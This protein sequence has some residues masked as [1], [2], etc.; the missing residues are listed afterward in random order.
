MTSDV[1]NYMGYQYITGS[2]LTDKFRSQMEQFPI[3]D[4]IVGDGVE[5]LRRE[6]D[7]FVAVTTSGRNYTGKT[8]IVASGKRS[9]RLSVPATPHFSK[10]KMWPLSAEVILDSRQ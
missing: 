1:E 7:E 6:D 9:R 4:I 10:A 2:E 8:V 3:V 5:K